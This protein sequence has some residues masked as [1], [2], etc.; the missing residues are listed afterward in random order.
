MVKAKFWLI[1]DIGTKANLAESLFHIV[2]YRR[3]ISLAK[4]KRRLNKGVPNSNSKE[5]IA[6][7]NVG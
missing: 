7:L 6:L 3:S 1:T 4:L 5:L 2:D